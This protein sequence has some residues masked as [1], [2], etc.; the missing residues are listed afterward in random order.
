MVVFGIRK[1]NNK[2]QREIKRV[3]KKDFLSTPL[4]SFFSSNFSDMRGNTALVIGHVPKNIILL[5]ID[6]TA[7]CPT[8]SS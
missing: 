3:I 6:I 1:Y 8:I 4:E 5:N 2:I 7:Y